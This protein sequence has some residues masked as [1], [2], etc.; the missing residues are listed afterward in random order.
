MPCG[1]LELY[2]LYQYAKEHVRDPTFP[3]LKHP[4]NIIIIQGILGPRACARQGILIA[5]SDDVATSCWGSGNPDAPVPA[6]LA[7]P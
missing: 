1:L 4:I 2:D 3:V 6:L 5:L 7:S